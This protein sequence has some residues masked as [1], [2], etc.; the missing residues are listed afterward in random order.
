[1]SHSRPSSGFNG[2]QS[3]IGVGSTFY[4]FGHRRFARMQRC[5]RSLCRRYLPD[6]H[7]TVAGVASYL[8]PYV[9]GRSSNTALAGIVDDGVPLLDLRKPEAEVIS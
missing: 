3:T 8:S 5:L 1:M 4:L 7:L 6:S 9:N 2:N